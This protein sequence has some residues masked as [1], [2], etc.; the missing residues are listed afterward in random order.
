VAAALV[1]AHGAAAKELDPVKLEAMRSLVAEAWMLD[2]AE[3]AGR[4]TRA[5]AATLRDDLSE[6][7]AKLDKDPAF[8]TFA[9]QARSALARRDD[10][11][12]AALRDRLVA[13]E[14]SHGRAD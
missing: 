2:Q 12:L 4:V 11:A 10:G 7:L 6:G 1:F 3:S 9:N 5:Y 14:R 8:S 13:E